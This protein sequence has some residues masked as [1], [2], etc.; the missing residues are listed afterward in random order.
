MGC[1]FAKGTYAGS[2]VYVYTHNLLETAG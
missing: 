2:E 1:D